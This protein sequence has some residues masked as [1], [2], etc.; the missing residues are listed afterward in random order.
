MVATYRQGDP[1]SAISDG[2]KAAFYCVFELP[3]FI[4]VLLLFA[5]NLPQEF[6][7]GAGAPELVD[8]GTKPARGEQWAE[9]E[10]TRV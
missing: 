3:I 6:G 10:S 5:L 9:L 7:F 1:P 8:D 2:A 4:V